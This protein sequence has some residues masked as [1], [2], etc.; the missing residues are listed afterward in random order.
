MQDFWRIRHAHIDIFEKSEQRWGIG[1]VPVVV[2]PLSP[3]HVMVHPPH[4]YPILLAWA[5]ATNIFVA[6]FG[7]GKTGSSAFAPFFNKTSD[8]LTASLAN[9]LCSYEIVTQQ[10]WVQ[11]FTF[12]E[13]IGKTIKKWSISVL[14]LTCWSS[15]TPIV[16]KKSWFFLWPLKELQRILCWSSVNG[17]EKY[18]TVW[19]GQTCKGRQIEQFKTFSPSFI[20]THWTYRASKIFRQT[21]ISK[22]VLKESHLELH[23]ENSLDC[24][25]DS[26]HLN[27]VVV[28]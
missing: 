7:S 3:C 21:I 11:D 18:E 12:F 27:K 8:L 2:F 9:S 20:A 24:I 22:R 19:T 10:R 6:F 1:N 25:I 17:N 14:H 26:S 4:W 16:R 15:F 28:H 5:P 13:F 23:P